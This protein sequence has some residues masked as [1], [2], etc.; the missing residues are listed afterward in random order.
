MKFTSILAVYVLFWWMC[1]FL[2][3]PLRLKR[4]DDKP[5]V[6]VPGE[7][8]GAPPRFSPGRTAL[9]TTILA[10]GLFLL[11]YINYVEGWVGPD[12]FDFYSAHKHLHM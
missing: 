11:F 12:A 8:P 1:L 7:M 10:A 2:V 4:R 9:W 5:D 6:P 3:L